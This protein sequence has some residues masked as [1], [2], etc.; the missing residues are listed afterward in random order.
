MIELYNY[1]V[2]SRRTQITLTDRQ[3]ALLID[4]SIRSG[5]PMA[6]LIR[7]AVDAVYR[8]VS[9]RGF[10]S[11]E[12]AMSVSREADAARIARRVAPRKPRLHDDI[13]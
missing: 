12:V 6:E 13:R 3:H 8:P 9:R 10:R 1:I 11:W 4:E 5:L 2:G 7:R